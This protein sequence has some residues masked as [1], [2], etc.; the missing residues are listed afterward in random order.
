MGFTMGSKENVFASLV[1]D[2]KCDN[3]WALCIN[4]DGL[5]SNGTIT[6]GGVDERL[7]I[8]GKVNYVEDVGLG[9]HSV[10]VKSLTIG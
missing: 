10:Q 7:S 6:I 9:F 5:K 1:A 8:D 2:G 3:I 4:N